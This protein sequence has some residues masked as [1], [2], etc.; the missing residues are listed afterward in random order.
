MCPTRPFAAT[1]CLL[2]GLGAG[3]VHAALNLDGTQAESPL[4]E[5][6]PSPLGDL[7]TYYPDQHNCPLPCIDY[8]NMHSW[9]AYLSVSRL[10]RCKEPM[11][12]Q[13]SITQPLDDP[14]SNILIRS[15]A[16][17]EPSFMAFSD[18]PIF[19]NESSSLEKPIE[20]PK[21]ASELVEASLDIAPACSFVG[22]R[23]PG[24]LNLVASGSS[25]GKVDSANTDIVIEGLRK[26]FDAPDNCDEN[27]AFA[28]YGQTVASIYIGP[29]LGKPTVASALEALARRNNSIAANRAV[30]QLCGSGRDSA[31]TIGIAIDTTGNLAAVQKMAAEWSKAKCVDQ[32]DLTPRG[33]VSIDVFNIAGAPLNTANSTLSSNTTVFASIG[34]GGKRAEEKNNIIS[35]EK[36]APCRFIQVVSGDGCGSL[37]SRCA[38]SAAD[39]TK[40]NPKAN[41]CSTLQV[42]D[43]VCCSAGDP[44]TDPKPDPPQPGAD[45]ICAMYLIQ[46]GDTCAGLAKRFG[47]TVEDLVRWNQGSTWGWTVCERLLLGYNMCLSEG[48]PGLPP[49]QAG[50]ECGPLVPGTKLPAS[51]LV[52]MAE[53]NPCPLKACCSNWGY[54]GVFPAHCDINAPIGGGP[55]TKKDGFQSTCVSNCGNDIK[56]NSGPPAAFQ[57]IGYYSSFN[58]ERECLRLPARNANTDGSYTHIHWAFA[59]IDPATWKPI[60]KE[61]SKGQWAEFKAL[62]NVKRIVSFGG[63]ALSTEPATYNIIRMAIINNRNLFATNLAAFAKAEGID[64]IDIDWEYPGAPDILVGGQPIGKTTDGLDYLKFLTILKQQMGTGSVSIA[65]PASYWY[66]KAFPIDRIANVIDYIVYMT[67][68]LHGQWDAGN[69]NAYDQ[70]DSGRC[71]RSHV[72][73]T[74]TR[75]TLAIITKAGVPNNKIFVGEASYGR[76]FRMVQNG[77]WGPM[78]DFTGSRTQSDANPGRCTKTGGYL[79]NAEI[80]EIIQRGGA[81]QMFHDTRSDSDILL[82]QGDYVSYMTPTTKNKRRLDWQSLN[83]AGSVD[84]ALD[85]QAFTTYDSSAPPDRP[86]DGM[87]GCV[88]GEDDTVNSANLCEFS[89]Q[90]GFCPSTLC[91]CTA[92]DIVYPLPIER[93]SSNIMAIDE[94]NPDMNRLCLFACQYGY[95]P[96]EVCTQIPKDDP[97]TIED[98]PNGF[99]YEDARRQNQ[100]TCLVYKDRRMRERSIQQCQPVCQEAV[101]AAAEAGRTSNYGCSG[102]YPLDKPIPWEQ[103]P[104]N[105]KLLYAPGKCL[106]DN[107]L[108]NEL[109]DTVIEALPIIAQIGCYIL[110]S[111]FK[112]ILDIGLEAIPV[113]G[114]LDAGL[115]MAATAAQTLA[116][117]YPETEKPEDAFSWW[118]SPCGGT[119]LVPDEV[120]RVFDILN[121]V[122]GG[123]S[124]FRPPKNI[125][126]G[127]GR[128][129]DDANPTDRSKPK[130]GG[131]NPN[132]KPPANNGKKPCRIPPSK[133]T[134]RIRHTLREQK[135]FQD[136]T[137]MSEWIITS[138]TYAPNATP[139]KIAKKCDAIWNQACWHY[140]SAIRNNPNWQTLTCPPSAATTSKDKNVVTRKVVKTWTAQHGGAGWR[141]QA[142][143][144]TGVNCEADE[145]P[146]LYLL[147]GQSTAYINVGQPGG[148]LVR[149]LNNRE[150]TNAAG[151]WKGVCFSPLVGPKEI[152]DRKLKDTVDLDPKMAKSD[153]T[154]NGKRIFQRYGSLNVNSRPEFSVSSWPPSPPNDGLNANPCWPSR[155]APL[156]PGFVL[157]ENDPYYA[158]NPRPYNYKAAYDPPKNGA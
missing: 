43:Y 59:E 47:V 139:T 30:A 111:S 95:C 107:W 130:P 64:G 110:M 5:D 126:R 113:G 79:S 102:L 127:S 97:L 152:S 21:K 91:S 87:P 26:F 46:N 112:L 140:S 131:G 122:A 9:I 8:A 33:D 70:C 67:Y 3:I 72:N 117:V 71:I 65:A 155:I 132:P 109:V 73:L 55:G 74:E 12:L 142:N 58:F 157:L 85:L 105:S 56:Q 37:V 16:L 133:S 118:L 129:G 98:S 93:D 101:D 145:Y 28:F 134:T 135:C 147:D 124:S 25:G 114:V 136:T 78:C 69:P 82:Y 80:D 6:D 62:Q 156:D 68:D 42:G 14:A 103:T 19:R 29:G 15:C 75:N 92:T 137:T 94:I 116:Y 11:L 23:V 44:H 35:L 48:N 41:L 108:L 89:C 76:S 57:R 45:G 104:G 1:V 51:T 2:L 88:S 20:N 22:T 148:Q 13:L 10:E 99:D 83:F 90:L 143:R 52:N 138:L 40:F 24:K 38:I 27:F 125:P 32:G 144:P 50:T 84:W 7:T 53:L 31:R 150:N 86:E 49:P 151:M 17:A 4:E 121:T 123:V 63:W 96:P 119:E 81:Q 36:R 39:F 154:K 153:T 18:S 34:R 141:D 54:C 61:S 77:C 115:D 158:M 120:K 146:P 106:C 66:L 149:H 60:I 100:R 128:K